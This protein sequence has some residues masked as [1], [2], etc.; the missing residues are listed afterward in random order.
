MNT[1]I[2]NCNLE[3]LNEQKEQ[4]KYE[5]TQG[6]SSGFF[7][8]FDIEAG[9][10]KTRTAESALIEAY[11]K[12]GRKSILVRRNDEDCRESMKIMNEAAKSDIAFAYNN[13]DVSL[14]DIKH[15]NK[16]LSTIPIVIITHQK[17]RVLMK[18]SNKRKLFSNDRKN[19]IVDEF[20]STVEVISV[21]EADIKTFRILFKK[22]PIISQAF[23]KA[24]KWIV[25]FFM[26]WNKE[27]SC[28]RFVNIDDE[29]PSKNFNELIKLI[30]ANVTNEILTEW[31]YGIFE[32]TNPVE[33]NIDLLSSLKT[34]KMLCDR[35]MEYKQLFTEMCVYNDK[36]LYTTDPRNNYWF[37]DNN[38]MLDASGE[39]QSA[40][41]LNHD[42][43]SLQHCEKVLN[44]SNWKII[45]I[46]V[47]TTSAGKERI[48]N[49]YDVVNEEIKKYGK[50]ILVIGKKNEMD[51]IDV[52]ED[53]K[54]YF[55]NVTGSNKWYDI[56][57]VAI[58]QTHNLSD[59]DYILKYLHY[60]KK[61]IEEKI[62]L[63]GYRSGRTGYSSYSFK[64]ERLE[65]IRVRWIA[66]EIYQAI[67]RVNRNMQYNTDVLIFINNEKVIELLKSQM[68]N[69]QY[70][71]IKYDDDKFSFIRNKQDDYIDRLQKSSYATKFIDFLAEVQNGLHQEFI[72]DKNRL[73][74]VKVRNYLGINSSGNFSN[75]VLKKTEVIKYC[76][77]R[78]IDLSGQYIK[79]PKTG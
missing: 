71:V 53:N 32:C 5:I 33:T 64:D 35:L 21:S 74:K 38:I 55:G 12:Y 3:L 62:N 37:L 22:D 52:P 10:R 42:E 49:F 6:E 69:C 13:E 54:G 1:N 11:Y 65:E 39:L 7:N 17:Y 14:S 30:K 79:L 73:S 4:L 46:P 48:I 78:N 72:D 15:V 77:V 66:S 75:K 24:M 56:K 47:N 58:I 40:Y 36:K 28:R 61:K 31:K 16:I 9:C 43:F 29:H 2:E 63:S 50:D 8:V 25:D 27:N 23:E 41:A 70:E 60:G 44:H 76:Q 67:K 19:L 51:M 26:T 45:N 68:K 20:I 59:V 18:D 34:V 57:N